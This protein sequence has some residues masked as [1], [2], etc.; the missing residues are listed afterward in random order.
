MR[1]WQW[2]KSNKEAALDMGS[3]RGGLSI[4]CNLVRNADSW[5]HPRLSQKL[6]ESETLGLRPRHSCI[7]PRLFYPQTTGCSHFPEA[8]AA[9]KQ[10]LGF[11][12]CLLTTSA[13]HVRTRAPKAGSFEHTPPPRGV[14]LSAPEGP[15]FQSRLGSLPAVCPLTS[16][17]TSLNCV[18]VRGCNHIC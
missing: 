4:G 3:N 1:G 15:S 11:E 10:R 12:P 9:G 14:Q 16:Q 7:T 13:V 6:S 5:A 18:V 8:C 17:S 2:E